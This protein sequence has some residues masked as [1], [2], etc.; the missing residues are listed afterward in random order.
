MLDALH[1]NQLNVTVET[2]TQGINMKIKEIRRIH[3]PSAWV[4]W[5]D[6]RLR[7]PGLNPGHKPLRSGVKQGKGR[8]D[9]DE[10]S[11]VSVDRR[12]GEVFVLIV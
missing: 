5:C 2:M 4:E 10:P 1:H 7:S 11:S 6:Q 8:R 9:L 12:N 3:F